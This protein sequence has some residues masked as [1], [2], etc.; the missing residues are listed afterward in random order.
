[1][2]PTRTT[3]LSAAAAMALSSFSTTAHAG[4]AWEAQWVP[5]YDASKVF[6]AAPNTPVCRIKPKMDTSQTPYR[7][8][9]E[10]LFVGAAYQSGGTWK[11][12][13]AS[14]S[15]IQ[16]LK[17]VSRGRDLYK[18]VTYS[19]SLRAISSSTIIDNATHRGLCVARV[20]TGAS[21]QRVPGYIFRGEE[22]CT[23]KLMGRSVKMSKFDFITTRNAGGMGYN[24]WF[25]KQDT[26]LLTQFRVGVDNTQSQYHKDTYLCRARLGS[27]DYFGTTFQGV[28]P[29]RSQGH[30][31]K[32]TYRTDPGASPSYKYTPRYDIFINAKPSKAGAAVFGGSTFNGHIL[33]PRPGTAICR[34]GS[35][36]GM[37]FQGENG[38]RYPAPAS[39]LTRYL[40]TRK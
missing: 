31:C 6:M 34:R 33:R 20:G 3:L 7:Y 37:K 22:K 21:T 32:L 5:S 12:G 25:A 9:P 36:L 30:Y 24:G 23:I 26:T 14:G 2:T 11:C 15:D 1:M 40:F 35:V 29:N 17:G 16:F 19:S 8:R 27:K 28:P 18:L 10:T 39:G 4:G 13:D 38:C